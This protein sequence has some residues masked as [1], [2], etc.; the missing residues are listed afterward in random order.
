M[1]V[2]P[3]RAAQAGR[4]VLRD[5]ILAETEKSP[6]GIRVV[7]ECQIA[8][9]L[10]ANSDSVSRKLVLQRYA[11]ELDIFPHE[12]EELLQRASPTRLAQAR[13]RQCKAKSTTPPDGLHPGDSESRRIR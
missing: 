2:H 5:R 13:S 7:R 11:T 6:A 12:L 1:K 3:F 10:P 4:Q 9:E 8:L